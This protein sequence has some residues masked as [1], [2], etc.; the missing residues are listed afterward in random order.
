MFFVCCFCHIGAKKTGMIR[1][2]KEFMRAKKYKEA[3]SLSRGLIN[4]A[5]EGLNY[6]QNYDRVFLN[7]VVTLGFLG[8]ISCIILQIVED[9]SEVIKEASKLDKGSVQPMVETVPLNTATLVLAFLAL[10]LLFIQK[11]P[12]MYYSY[13]LLPLVF[14]NQISN[15][16]RGLILKSKKHF[17]INNMMIHPT[18]S[19]G[20]LRNPKPPSRI[21]PP[22]LLSL[23]VTTILVLLQIPIGN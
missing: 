16:V 15:N 18:L 6:Y 12:W 19:I 13:C 5:L 8:W 9:H 11:A 21:P 3:E 4:L 7:L 23:C 2:I 20:P 1:D 17:I 22:S 10:I 14:W